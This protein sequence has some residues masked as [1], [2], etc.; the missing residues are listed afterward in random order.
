MDKVKVGIVGCGNIS[1]IYF[2][3]LTKLFVNTEVYACADV[4]KER[5]E[6]AAEKYGVPHVWSTEELLASPDIQIVVNLTTPKGHFDVCKQALLS[7]KHVYVEKPLSLEL[8]HGQELVELAAEKGLMLGCAPDTFLGAGIQ[9]CRKLIDDGFIG[10]PV[11][12]SA[13][14]VCHGHESWHP[15]PEFYYQAGG[16]PMFDM[17]P[18]YL[19]ALVSLMGPAATVAGMTKTSFAQRTITSEKKFG[20]QIDVEVPT[21]VAGTVQFASGAVATMIT[22]FDVWDSTLPRIEIYGTRGTLIVPD[23]NTFGGPV[24]L[25][26]AGGTGFMEIPLVHNYAV[27]SR[28]IGVA[29]M[30]DCITSGNRPRA[31]GELANHVLEIMHAFHTSSDTKR[32]VE[33]ATSCEQPRPLPLGLIKGYIS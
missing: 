16:G 31:G 2:E 26:P 15:D 12:A 25:K 11:A 27:N 28:G 4:F 24:L 9:T 33:L 21:H 8:A 30:A 32:Y 19:T 22:S 1:G 20:K 5:A 18:Y 23:P 17:G 6:E 7:G 29:D 13:F 14:M 10:E 3:N